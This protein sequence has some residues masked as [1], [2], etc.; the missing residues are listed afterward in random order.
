MLS[1]FLV[2]SASTL[3]LWPLLLLDYLEGNELQRIEKGRDVNEVLIPGQKH[4]CV[5]ESLEEE[6]TSLP[7]VVV[8]RGVSFAT[9]KISSCHTKGRD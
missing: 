2:F 4:Y 1:S 5:H 6:Q 9:E 3:L 8:C 7:F